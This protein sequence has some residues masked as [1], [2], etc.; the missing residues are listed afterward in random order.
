M[1]RIFTF[2]LA[3][4]ALISCQEIVPENNPAGTITVTPAVVE[5]GIEGGKEYL[6]LTLNSTVKQWEVVQNA[7]SDWCKLSAKS[8][9]SSTT[10]TLTVPEYLG[11]P[12]TAVLQFTSPGCETATV[13]VTQNGIGTEPIPAGTAPGIN[14][15]E[16]G[17][18]TFV[19]RD[20]DAQ[21]KSYDFAYLIGDFSDWKVLP[22]Y[23]M[24]R[25]E[26]AGC[27]WYTM[28]G[29][30]PTKE[31]MFQYY[32]GYMGGEGRAYADP[33]SEIVYEPNDRYITSSTYPGLP[34]YPT[35]TK[36]VVSAFKV[37]KTDYAWTV[38]D[39]QI[40]DQNDLVI[41]ELHFRDFTATG[42]I[43]GAMK[44][45]DYIEALGV[46]AIELMPVHE[47]DGSNSWG[48]NPIAFFALEK[49]YGTRE[50]YK[51]F[52]DECHKRG[53]AVI[54]DVVYNH[55]HENHPMAGLYFDWNIYKPTANN[56]WF[57][58]DATHPHSV[59]NDFNHE[60]AQVRDYVK[61][62]LKYLIEEYKVDGFRFDL[63][64]GF[65]QKKSYDDAG[66]SAYDASRVAILTDYCTYVKS[67][68]QN[69]VVIFE[70]FA[71]SE[72]NALAKAGAKVWRKGNWE[73]R[74]A[75]LGGS[76]N[77]GT[78]WTGNGDLFGAYVGYMESHDEERIC[79]G[80]VQK[81]ESASVS[82]GICGT[83]T[84][85][86]TDDIVM[87]ADA[88]FFVAK[89][90][91]VAATDMFKIRGNKSWNDAYNYGASSKGYKLPKNA[92]YS[93][94]LGAASQD[95][96]APAAGTYDIYFSPDAAKVWLME[97]G[98]RP[99]DSEVPEVENEDPLVV[100]M[101][102]AGACAAFCFTVPGPKMI[103]QFGELGYD[104]SIEVGGRTGRKPL[105]WEY[106]DVPARKALYDTYAGLLRF[107]KENPRF[108]DKNAS[109]SWTSSGTIKTIKCT[110]D[111]KSFFVV[112]NFAKG[113]QTA[114]VTLPS[115]GTWTNWFD[116]SEK[117]TG[118]SQT[119]K[120]KAGEFKLL[121]NL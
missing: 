74:N 19:F 84:N 91:T 55:A 106:Y 88:P 37:Q 63:T 40:E 108:F 61:K 6:T 26:A 45:L 50:M 53:M 68:D 59:F 93:L 96:A 89:N 70:H 23:I 33:F 14:Y 94:T 104:E 29:V 107:R 110:A 24:K 76:D 36:G 67:V 69:A 79:F 54:I 121:V 65:T 7:D 114:S 92:G 75:V 99:S 9:K 35:A 32:L 11:D 119:F 52:I 83:F 39:Y 8:G 17:S 4:I 43:N 95:M 98:K 5:F 56:P 12:R 116:S 20:K 18:V 3:L 51:Q 15:N 109:F 64:K 48:Y 1:K 47:F 117:F 101:R 100:A 118:A 113:I 78:I 82:W 38:A 13:T 28:T 27:W 73:F 44:K 103:W 72:N 105:H 41:Y 30:N 10:V 97:A 120:L 71:D 34:D 62:S 57:N 22:E 87:T 81:E 46:N 102:R 80:A 31:Y 85:N 2:C 77:F 111:G 66:A 90:V 25:D 21:G 16:D 58:V 115:A 49:S 86:W 112:G 42:D 60:N